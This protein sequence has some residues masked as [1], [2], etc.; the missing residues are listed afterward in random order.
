MMAVALVGAAISAYGQIQQGRAARAAAE[1]QSKVAQNNAIAA[2]RKAAEDERRFRVQTSRQLGTM[3]A[4]YGASGVTLEGS[5]LD[6]I[7]DSTFTA[8]LDALT[9]RGG[10]LQESN[11]FLAE[12][13]LSRFQGRAAERGSRL[14]AAGTLLGGFAKAYGMRSDTS[15]A[16]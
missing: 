8:E 4:A 5:P 14:S 2:Q 11:A 12:S 10:G 1:Y 6:V 15:T 7:D 9:I 3:R 16:A 13:R